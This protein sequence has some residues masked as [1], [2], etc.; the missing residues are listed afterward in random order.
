MT[1]TTTDALTAG[2]RADARDAAALLSSVR[3]VSVV[4]HVHPDADTIGAGL[5]LAL[6]LD[7]A[8]KDVEVA[9]ATP[10]ELPD[11]LRSLPGCH[12]LVAPEQIRRDADLVV[13]VDV[14]SVNR[15]GS[16]ADL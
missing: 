12:L 3:S 11:S 10:A 16:L 1:D 9:F 7:R 5:A 8:G 15:L 4:C 14:P 13:T 2:V 6:V